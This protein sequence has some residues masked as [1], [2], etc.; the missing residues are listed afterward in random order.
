MLP[1]D[2]RIFL[3]VGNVVERWTGIQLENK[4]ATPGLTEAATA[5]F[6]NA[7]QRLQN[8]AQNWTLQ[9]TQQI[10]VTGEK[11]KELQHEIRTATRILRLPV[12]QIRPPA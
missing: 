1:H 9:K 10:E 6:A 7:Y 8:T 3:Q 11:I 12:S 4:L 2:E 5:Y